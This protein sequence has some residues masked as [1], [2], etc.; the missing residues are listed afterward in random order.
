MLIPLLGP[1]LFVA[2]L[3]VLIFIAT[4]YCMQLAKAFGKDEAYGIGLMLLGP[5]FEFI[6]A[7]DHN[8]E[9]VGPQ[10]DPNFFS[11][12]KSDMMNEINGLKKDQSTREMK[13]DPYTG[14]PLSN[15]KLVEKSTSVETLA[16]NIANLKE[17]TNEDDDISVVEPGNLK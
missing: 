2:S 12:V 13:F 10:K 4:F 7:F 3:L 14:Q 5:V 17:D 11:S 1:I 16:E 8:V 6:L 9:Y 15:E